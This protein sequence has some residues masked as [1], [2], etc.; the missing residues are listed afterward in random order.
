MRDRTDMRRSTRMAL[1]GAAVLVGVGAVAGALRLADPS[2]RELQ[3]AGTIR[4]GYAVEAPYAFVTPDGEITGESPEMAKRIVGR[5]G[6]GTIVWRGMEFRSLIDELEAGNI[7]LIASGLFVTPERARRVAFSKI[8]FQVHSGLLVAKGNPKKLC[9]CRQV[10]H[11]PSVRLAVLSG[12]VEERLYRRLGMPGRRL[13]V[14][15][16]ALT[17]RTA[18]ANGLAD[19]LA[20]SSPSVN[21]IA[22]NDPA[23][24]TEAADPF[25][26]A[27]EEKPGC[28]AFAFR[29]RDRTLVHAWNAALEAYLGSEEHLSCVAR[30][31][32]APKDLAHL[33]ARKEAAGP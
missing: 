2:L 27:P 12:S 5:L 14:T 7:D 4:V 30:F 1:A 28:G 6:I 10:L 18:V 17:G 15:P 9:S 8:T 33:V 23:C 25:E 32:F 19:A 21:W 22:L 24:A 11:D 20:L 31:G 29:K 13:I 16:D 3:R 26:A